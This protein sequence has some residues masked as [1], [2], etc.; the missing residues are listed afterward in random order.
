MSMGSGADSE[1]AD[2]GEGGQGEIRADDGG[3]CGIRRSKEA[4]VQV[5]FAS[6]SDVQPDHIGRRAASQVRRARTAAHSRRAAGPTETFLD[7]NARQG[8]THLKS[9]DR[10]GLAL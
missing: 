2:V 8:S 9:A 5:A 4:W 6:G 10:N 1:V 7:P 3:G